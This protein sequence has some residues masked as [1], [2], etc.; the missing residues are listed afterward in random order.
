MDQ[1]DTNNKSNQSIQ[2]NMYI[3]KEKTLIECNHLKIELYCKLNA[4]IS[5]QLE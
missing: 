3:C 1:L 2:E 5:F 4:I